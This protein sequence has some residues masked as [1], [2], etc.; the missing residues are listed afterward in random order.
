MN[1]SSKTLFY[2]QTMFL[3]RL[4]ECTMAAFCKLTI[5][6]SECQSSLLK[7]VGIMLKNDMNFQGHGQSM[8]HEEIIELLLKNFYY[9]LVV[10]RQVFLSAQ[11]VQFSKVPQVVGIVLC[12]LKV[13]KS[14]F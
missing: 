6:L 10:G 7:V 11:L 3:F 14:F 13:R 12:N 5:S 1:W 4:P 9:N 2:I 8:F